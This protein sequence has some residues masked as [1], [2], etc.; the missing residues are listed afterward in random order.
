MKYSS[1]REIKI[2]Q[3]SLIGESNIVLTRT[4]ARNQLISPRNQS[5]QINGFTT[6]RMQKMHRNVKNC[7]FYLDYMHMQP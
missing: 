7:F 4:R 2:N 3:T 5:C 6:A 1:E